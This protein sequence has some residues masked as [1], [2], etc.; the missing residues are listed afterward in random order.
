M[1]A[2]KKEEDF[3]VIRKKNERLNNWE[4]YYRQARILSYPLIINIPTGSRCNIRCRFCTDRSGIHSASDYSDMSLDEFIDL[5]D[6]GDWRQAFTRIKTLAL[7]G[8]GEPFVNPDYE[9]IFN[10]ITGNYPALGISL[11]TNG[12]MFSANWAEK[13][14]AVSNSEINFS[15]NAASKETYRQLTGSSHFE[16]IIKNIDY[17]TRR[18]EEKMSGT[19]CVT[20][21][22]VATTTNIEELP[23]FVDLAADLKADSI[24]VQD[25]MILN[26]ETA[27]LSLTNSPEIGE[28]SFRAAEER[29]RKRNIPFFSF[30]THN[31][32]YFR[33]NPMSLLNASP[34]IPP[35]HEEV[36]SP[37]LLQ[38][39]CFDPWER[40]MV[41]ENGDVFPCCR[42]QN[43]SKLPLGNVKKQ[44]FQEIW[45]GPA[46]VALRRTINTNN[47]PP[48]CACCPRKSGHA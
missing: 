7:Y 25:I 3:S 43:F 16:R 14:L 33:E 31:V 36:P 39:D 9:R 23:G 30:T 4:K 1:Q 24:L 20:L 17:L 48:N 13:L 37:Y 19:P 5:Y 6:T 18:R 29:A 40:F 27:R 42:Y 28:L 26:D 15:V 41:G 32:D 2:I 22:Y 35:S 21:S 38:T 34:G 44:R 8:W 11:C 10:H 46:Y 12:I 45:N 47:P